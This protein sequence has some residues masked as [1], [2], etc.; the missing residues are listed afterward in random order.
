MPGERETETRGSSQGTQE[1]LVRSAG[2]PS[3]SRG[4]SLACLWDTTTLQ[5]GNPWEPKDFPEEPRG[6][7]GSEG[8]DR[9]GSRGEFSGSGGGVFQAPLW[10]TRGN[11]PEPAGIP[12]G[13]Q[14]FS[15]HLPRYPR[16]VFRV[17]RGVSPVLLRDTRGNPQ[18]PAGLPGGKSRD[19]AVLLGFPCGGSRV[20]PGYIYIPWKHERLQP[21]IRGS[22]R[23][24]A[25]APENPRDPVGVRVF[26]WDFTGKLK[27]YHGTPRVP[28][29]YLSRSSGIPGDHEILKAGPRVSFPGEPMGSHDVPQIPVGC[30]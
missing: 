7:H 2:R 8:V 11:T 28:A 22:L 15:W 12:G 4:K 26:P 21:G 17:P 16:D 1:N 14:A 25:G 9:L 5:A 10:D 24:S 23:E 20:P 6:S 18:E 3:G 27:G 30:I 19:F 13:S 29:G